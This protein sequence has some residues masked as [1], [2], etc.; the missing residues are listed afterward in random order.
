MYA[1]SLFYKKIK[2]FANM[3]LYFKKLIVNLY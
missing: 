2:Q 3:N 1:H